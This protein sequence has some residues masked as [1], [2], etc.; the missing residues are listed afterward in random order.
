MRLTLNIS[1]RGALAGAGLA[2]I[3]ATF[4]DAAASTMVE[5]IW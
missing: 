1:M 5:A 2:S 4:S 3:G